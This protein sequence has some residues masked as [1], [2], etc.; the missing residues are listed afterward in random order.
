MLS[1]GLGD[2]TGASALGSAASFEAFQP[3]RLEEQTGVPADRIRQLARDFANRRPSLAIGGGS[4]GSYVNGTEGVTAILSLNQLAG[5]VGRQG[6]MR[7]TPAPPIE[8]LAAAARPSPMNDWQ[9]LVD[10]LR[11]GQ[12]TGAMFYGADPVHDLPAA[13]GLADALRGSTGF[14]VSF[15]S[16]M[17]DTTVFA[18]LI[19][20]SHLLLEDWGDDTPDP[21]PGFP[22]LSLQQPVVMPLYDT[23]S[24]PDTLITLGAQLGGGVQSQLPW[25]SFKELLQTDVQGL[26]QQTGGSVRAT[27]DRFWQTALQQGGWWNEGQTSPPAAA[28]SGS[29]PTAG[30]QAQ[31]D[32]ADREFPYHLVVFPHNTLGTGEAAHLPWMQGTPDPITSVTWQTWVEVNPKLAADL[33]L[34]EG[35]IVAVVSQH[36]RVEV[37]VYVNPAASPNVLAMPLGQGHTHYGRWAEKR[38]VN[39]MALIAPVADDMTGALAYGA[40]RVRLE[41]TGRRMSVPKFEGNVPAF[42]D[43][44]H[45]IIQVTR[46]A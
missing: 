31:F 10:Q 23:R 6:G 46:G 13:M 2:A 7:V 43:P 11:A 28:P 44:S 18:D 45:N 32:G 1:E 21:G 3:S 39:P 17:D 40:T 19:L 38:G 30:R 26:Q 27:A 9:R 8:G 34:R 37:P 15:S 24:F 14:T 5:N 35:D 25:T 29:Q 41:R 4:A 22:V 33:G 12:V 16:F 42:V 20:P 36:G